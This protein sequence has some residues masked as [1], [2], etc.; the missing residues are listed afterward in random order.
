M[1]HCDLALAVQVG[2]EHSDPGLL[3]W[4]CGERCDLALAVEV[5]WR[6]EEEAAAEE[7]EAGGGRRDS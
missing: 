7:Q 2:G 6:T 1:E 4:S 5:R 3:F